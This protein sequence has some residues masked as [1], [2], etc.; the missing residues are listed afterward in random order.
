M[1]TSAKRPS[2]RLLLFITLFCAATEFQ[3]NSCAAQDP[4][5]E[6]PAGPGGGRDPFQRP[7][8]SAILPAGAAGDSMHLTYVASVEHKDLAGV[9][10]FALTQDGKFLYVAPWHGSAIVTF[11]IGSDGTPVHSKSLAHPLLK[12]LIQLHLSHEEDLLAGICLRSNTILLFARD[13]LSGELKPEGFSRTDLAWPVSVRFSPDSSYLYVVDARASGAAA[14]ADSRIFGFTVSGTGGLTEVERFSHR[15]LIGAR[16]ILISPDGMYCYVS[17]STGGSV[18]V[19]GRDGATGKLTHLQT[20]HDDDSE[21]T[22]LDGVH[23]GFF[24][25]Q[26]N[27]VYFVAGR[28]RGQSGLTIFDRKEDGRLEFRNEIAVGPAQFGGGNHL[29]VTDD[30]SRIFLSGTTGD[31]LAIVEHDPSRNELQIESILRHSTQRNLRGPSGL[32]FGP[33]Q[34]TLYVAAEN[35]SAITVFEVAHP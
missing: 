14:D 20:I 24:N 6:N 27:R 23:A 4:F 28:F 12:G 32:I 7:P 26:A 22:L 17:C 8:A 1:L 33:N 11:S 31:S 30:E 9:N 35:G 18:M 21:A 5:G 10:R 29:A 3:I 13:E 15:D 25:H 16:D 2:L 34:R 19:L